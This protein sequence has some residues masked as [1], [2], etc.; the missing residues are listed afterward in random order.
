MGHLHHGILR[1]ACAVSSV[2]APS[3]LLHVARARRV[4]ASCRK[5]AFTARVATSAVDATPQAHTTHNACVCQARGLACIRALWRTTRPR[6]VF[7]S[8]GASR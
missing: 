3:Q 5:D 6:E 1:C 8:R 7:G 4:R 2:L